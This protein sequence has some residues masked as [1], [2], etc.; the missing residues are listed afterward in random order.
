MTKSGLKPIAISTFIIFSSMLSGLPTLVE[1]QEGK[2]KSCYQPR[3]LFGDLSSLGLE[4]WSVGTTLATSVARFDFSSKKAALAT[5]AGA[6]IAFRYYGKTYLGNKSEAAKYDFDSA[7][8]K[9]INTHYGNTYA[10]DSD[11]VYVPLSSI[12]PECRATTADIGKERADK[13]ASSIFSITPIV[14]YSKQ[15]TENDLSIQPALMIG[16]LD[17]IISIGTG[18]NLTGQEKGKMFLLMSLGYG[19][20]F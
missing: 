5:G 3:P 17:D 19:F 10:D 12:K 14:Y 7:K 2:A 20:K 4:N 1:A 15:T 8:L 11:E 9:S 6:G 18:F 16:F 13:L